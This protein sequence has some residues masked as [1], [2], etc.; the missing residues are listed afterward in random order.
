MTY[1]HPLSDVHSTVVGCRSGGT[2]ALKK[3]RTDGYDLAR[4]G[5]PANRANP[6][7]QDRKTSRSSF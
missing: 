7:S 1:G 5:S 2:L 4:L 6:V 3:K